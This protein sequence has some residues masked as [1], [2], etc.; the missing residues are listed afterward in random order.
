MDKEEQWFTF[1][2]ELSHV[3]GTLLETFTHTVLFNLLNN[4]V[5]GDYP[6]FTVEKTETR[7]GK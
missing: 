2:S 5:G 7:K 4:K 6:Y 3:P 1:F